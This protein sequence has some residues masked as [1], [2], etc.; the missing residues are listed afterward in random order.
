MAAA[1]VTPSESE[2]HCPVCGAT[3]IF[4]VNDKWLY[5]VFAGLGYLMG[6][7]VM[8]HGRQ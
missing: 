1:P 8:V 2:K 6:Y 3:G 7:L 4:G 5:L